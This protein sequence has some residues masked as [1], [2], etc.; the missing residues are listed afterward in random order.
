MAA[1]AREA[2]MP[3]RTAIRV[4]FTDDT[5]DVTGLINSTHRLANGRMLLAPIHDRDRPPAPAPTG[6]IA[7]REFVVQH[8]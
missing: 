6:K 5:A 3:I 4:Q 7:E 1:R 2:P 8:W